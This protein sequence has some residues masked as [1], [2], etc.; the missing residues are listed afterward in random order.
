VSGDLFLCLLSGS[1]V[2]WIFYGEPHTFWTSLSNVRVI[3][4]I[5]RVLRVELLC[6]V[7]TGHIL[8]LE[9]MLLGAHGLLWLH[10]VLSNI[11]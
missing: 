9:C 7:L 4:V 11:K 2:D 6:Q 3:M 5:I 1:L 10:L 8:A